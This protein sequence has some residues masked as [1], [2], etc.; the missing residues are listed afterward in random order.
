MKVT[1]AQLRAA[2]RRV[3]EDLISDGP[4]TIPPTVGLKEIN[5][6]FGL[7]GNT[8][9]QW[10][11]RGVLPEPDAPTSGN[12]GWKVPTIYRFAADTNREI[13]WD[14]WGIQSLGNEPVAGEQGDAQPM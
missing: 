14:P 2:V 8:S 1:K 13:V 12:P 7:A 5:R 11:A 10:K 3:A 4:L 9:Y 6:M